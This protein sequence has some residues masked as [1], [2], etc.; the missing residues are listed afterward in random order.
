MPHDQFDITKPW[1][2]ELDPLMRDLYHILKSYDGALTDF[3][4]AIKKALESHVPELKALK[5]H[6]PSDYIW[7]MNDLLKWIPSENKDGTW[8]YTHLVV[9]YW[10]FNLPPF[11]HN[12][13]VQTEIIPQNFGVKKPVTAW[14]VRY[15]IKMGEFMNTTDSWTLESLKSFEEAKEY[16]VDWY[17]GPWKTFNEFFS[18]HL[19]VPRT[20]PEP[21]NDRVIVS[22]ADSTYQTPMVHVNDNSDINVKGVFWNIDKLLS[23]SGYLKGGE[24]AGGLFIHSFLKPFDY[25][26]QHAPCSGILRDAVIVQ[27]QC[28]L[29]VIEEVDG[30]DGRPHLRPVRP[31][32]P[33][34][35]PKDGSSP[36]APDS[37]GYQ[38]LQTRGIFIIENEHLG[39]VAVLPVGMA[40]IS[41][42][43]TNLADKIGTKLKKGDEISWFECGGSDIIM[44]FQKK[45]NVELIV[46]PGPKAHHLQGEYVIKANYKDII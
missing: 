25:H 16:H 27:A 29:E 5:I 15:A 1:P 40:Q 34:S 7:F 41:S 28:Y 22:P 36:G 8:V 24:F 9:F 21:N 19:K 33:P 44:V 42:V 31:I 17:K 32:P 45:A 38:F 4:K 3:E 39:L 43:N 2:H 20:I 23:N 26:R 14:I 11:L 46:T 30:R 18:R 35:T 12:I 13:R 10:V 6:Y 37:T